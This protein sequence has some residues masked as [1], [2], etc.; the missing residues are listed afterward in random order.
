MFP[1]LTFRFII[2]V[3]NSWFLLTYRP[4]C[5]G[6][7]LILG[8]SQYAFIMIAAYDLRVRLFVVAGYLDCWVRWQISSSAVSCITFWSDRE[9][10]S[11]TKCCWVQSSSPSSETRPNEKLSWNMKYHY[12][13]S[14][15]QWL[16]HGID[17]NFGK[18]EFNAYT[19]T[20]CGSLKYSSI[21]LADIILST[22]RYINARTW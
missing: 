9:R 2:H 4:R 5:L 3:L 22:Y 14:Q 18:I 12:W 16:C 8:T 19:K 6:G 21:G 20:W 11:D 17:E 7:F 10:K 15:F 1:V 13:K